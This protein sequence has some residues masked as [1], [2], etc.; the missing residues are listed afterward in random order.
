MTKCPA[1][2][3]FLDTVSINTAAHFRQ[4]HEPEDF[5]LSPLGE[6]E[7]LVSQR[8]SKQRLRRLRAD[9]GDPQ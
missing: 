7:G 9:R 3:A 5:G 1:C 6:V 2:G 8:P 4:E